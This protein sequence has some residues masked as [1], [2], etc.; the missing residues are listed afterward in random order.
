MLSNGEKYLH[1]FHQVK[2]PL[3]SIT[4]MCTEPIGKEKYWKFLGIGI[5]Y[6]QVVLNIRGGQGE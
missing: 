5:L 1:V 6:L 2:E 3:A 4:S